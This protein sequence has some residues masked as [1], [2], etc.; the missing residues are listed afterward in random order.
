MRQ[1]RAS[2]LRLRL[3]SAHVFSSSAE[4]HVQEGANVLQPKGANN[5]QK[6][7]G[8]NFNED[9]LLLDLIEGVRYYIISGPSH[10]ILHTM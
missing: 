5:M 7:N 1:L 6:L 4:F 8:G 3:T 10:N 9:N 2:C